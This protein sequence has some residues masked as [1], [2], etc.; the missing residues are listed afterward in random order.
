[1]SCKST[2]EGKAAVP[3]LRI[4]GADTRKGWKVHWMP[5]EQREMK[6]RIRR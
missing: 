4:E 1:M 3:G 5:K 2:Q 6:K